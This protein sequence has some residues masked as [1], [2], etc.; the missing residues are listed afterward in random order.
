MFELLVGEDKI[1]LCHIDV[2]TYESTKEVFE[3]VD[4]RLVKGGVIVFDDY[5]NTGYPDTKIEIDEFFKNK[6]GA[7][8]QSPTGQAIYYV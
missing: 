8:M 4:K 1:K 7:L 6:P 5:G 3:Y 2:N